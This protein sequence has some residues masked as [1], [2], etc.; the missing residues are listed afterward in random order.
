MDR[1]LVLPSCGQRD[2]GA[3]P[4]T[5]DCLPGGQPRRVNGGLGRERG[6]AGGARLPGGCP[7]QA[8]AGEEAWPLTP[9]V[10][11]VVWDCLG[12]QY[13]LVVVPPIECCAGEDWLVAVRVERDLERR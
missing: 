1:G 3:E 2:R 6:R 13:A 11:W 8:W 9:E 12:G 7:L 10:R 5:G 4:E